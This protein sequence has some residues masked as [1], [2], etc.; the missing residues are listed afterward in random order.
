LEN[1]AG[2]RDQSWEIGM[3]R[4][5]ACCVASCLLWGSASALAE[6]DPQGPPSSGAG[7][8]STTLEP[9]TVTGSYIRRTNIESP[10]PVTTIDADEIL[11]S[12]LNS[13]ADVIRTVSADNSGTLSQ[14]FS[15]A[16]AGGADGVALRGLTVDATLVL[17]DGHRMA[18][19]PLTDDGQR[20]FVDIDSLPMAIVDR[21][22]VLKDGASATY[23]SDAI[24]GVVNVIL[25]KE[26]VGF[27]GSVTA[28]STDRGD[29]LSQR[30]A[31]TWGT[32]SL[33]ADGHNFYVSIE[34]RHQQ[35]IPQEARGSYIAASDLT[36]WGGPN[37]YGGV[38]NGSLPN[39]LTTYTVPGQVLP[40]S[41]GVVQN[42]T[43][44]MLPGCST[45]DLALAA[46][47]GNG[48]GG[49][50]WD[51]NA[52]KKLQPRTAGLD[53]STKWTQRLSG[54]WSNSLA[55]SYYLSQSEQYRQPNLYDVG[56]NLVP[57]AWAGALGVNQ[58][59]FN[60]ATSQVV[61][62]ATSLDNPF[63]PASPYFAAARSFYNS[64]GANFNSYIGDPA[65]FFGALTSLPEEHT[66]YGTDVYRVVDDLTNTFGTWELN[67]S[68][69]YVRDVTRITYQG[70]M[71]VPAFYAALANGYRVGQN[72]YLNSAAVNNSLVPETHDTATSDIAFIQAHASS[73]IFPLPGGSAQLA[74][75]LESRMIHE[76]NPG[77]PDAIEG[78]I[79]MDGS[80]YAKGEQTV[81]AA[82][83]ELVAPVLDSLEIDAAG[84]V[85]RYNTSAGS[86][87]TPKVGFKWTV[88]PQV[89]LRGTFAKGF[90]APGIAE[91]G[92]AGSASSVAPAPVDPVRCPVTGLVGDCGLPGSSVAVLTT[93][94]PN[95]KPETSRSYTFG[96]ILEPFQRNALTVDY[97]YIRRNGE[98]APAQY[99]PVNA[100]RTPEP[101]GAPLPGPIIEYLTPY[102]N[103]T[104]SITAGID[105]GWKT[106]LD[107]GAY[108]RITTILDATHLIQQ[109][110]TF[111]DVTYHYVGTVGPTA[112]SGSTGTP[113]NRGSLTID[114]TRGPLS[115]GTVLNYRSAMQG[116]DPSL[117]TPG[118][119]PTCLQLS[120]V[121]P[122][123]YVAGFGYANVYGQYQIDEH[124]QLMANV[125]N[126]TNRLPPLDTV[127]YGGQNYDASYD[128]AG[129]IGRF[130]E[131]TFRYRF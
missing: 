28:G 40:V 71:Y 123:C 130:M 16:M 82:F 14:A 127:T 94:N 111:G 10:S 27:D 66:M 92:Y 70:F 33:D 12:G 129:A 5:I 48:P 107:L 64:M 47:G 120:A 114:W 109:Q 57:F 37:L 97:F 23:G 125:T 112:L 95:L 108:G 121:N 124:M 105:A 13:I 18:N 36:P 2:I 91:S 61:L 85:D 25:K 74:V 89:A 100:I 122:H 38:V 17:V 67:A 86:A 80:F 1:A 98:I 7:A 113:G 75:G 103:A 6:P 3:S 117:D 29:G 4:V 69:G 77:E 20:Q 34:G 78:N 11:K 131:L 41:G 101:P 21:V 87:F 83:A 44:Y 110:Q 56:T 22:E 63:N 126:V 45:E 68:L 73:P 43:P 19:Y 31:A 50:A 106:L 93:S 26:F 54:G 60:P 53:V 59:Q 99:L 52:Y 46:I 42:Q 81:S 118:M 32:G 9:I 76:N 96:V 55:V 88:I 39:P 84:R 102:V 79:L 62:P 58:N 72:A 8:S 119:P 35:A 24:A 65:L 128:Q 49:C 90:R 30:F 115:L 104:Y 51:T 116:I 15:G